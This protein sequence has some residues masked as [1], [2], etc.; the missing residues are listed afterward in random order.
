[1]A[2]WNP[3]KQRWEFLDGTHTGMPDPPKEDR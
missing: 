3:R 2:T 1:M